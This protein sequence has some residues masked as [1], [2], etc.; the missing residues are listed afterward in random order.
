MV[1]G[2]APCHRPLP[3]YFDIYMH[4]AGR[5]VPLVHC[6]AFG[7]HSLATTCISHLPLHKIG[8]FGCKPVARE[9]ILGRF[10][11]LNAACTRRRR[12]SA[13][14]CL[15]FC[16]HRTCPTTPPA[17]SGPDSPPRRHQLAANKANACRRTK[18]TSGIPSPGRFFILVS[19][20]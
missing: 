17:Y 4:W 14:H 15:H 20:M 7:C 5:C 3:T 19:Y 10:F 9:R 8:G 13:Y 1:V 11:F 18:T 12:F 16:L 6:L 2:L